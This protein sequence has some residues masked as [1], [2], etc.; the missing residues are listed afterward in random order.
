MESFDDQS[1]RF[2]FRGYFD[3]LNRVEQ[4]ILPHGVVA[5]FKQAFGNL[6]RLIGGTV[7][8]MTAIS[9]P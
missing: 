6:A 5:L 9:R 4:A 2:I 8:A 7:Y 1:G 3:D